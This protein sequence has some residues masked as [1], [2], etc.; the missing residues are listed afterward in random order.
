LKARKGY[1]LSQKKKIIVLGKKKRRMGILGREG[2]KGKNAVGHGGEGRKETSPPAPW[3]K[4]KK[5]PD[6]LQR[7]REGGSSTTIPVFLTGKGRRRDF[8]RGRDWRKGLG[9]NS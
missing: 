1:P 8:H 5:N 2:K 9:I 7:K 4:R 6:S 3:R